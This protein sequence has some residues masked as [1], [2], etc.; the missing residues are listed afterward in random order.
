[1]QDPE[2]WSNPQGLEL[3]N[4]FTA[5]NTPAFT[6]NPIVNPKSKIVNRFAL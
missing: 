5:L 4:E 2:G 6:I 1:M 3:K